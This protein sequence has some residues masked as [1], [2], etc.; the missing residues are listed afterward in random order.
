MTLG[1]TIIRHAGLIALWDAG[2]WRGVLIE[3]PAGAGKSD[4][5]LRALH[6]GWTL[7]ADDRVMIWASGGRLFGR[8]PD[9]L[10][11]LMEIRGLDVVATPYRAFA[12]IDLAAEC[13]PAGGVERIPPLRSILLLEQAIPAI[14][15]VALEPSAPAKLARAVSHLG[16]RA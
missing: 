13:V 2:A 4:L 15:L 16:L 14:A 11:G 6:A 3:G 9:S 8:A 1:P 7:V 5:M 10:A 12:P